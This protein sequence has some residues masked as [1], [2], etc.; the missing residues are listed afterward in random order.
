MH[1]DLCPKCGHS[2]YIHG[3]WF[4][5]SYHTMYKFDGSDADSTEPLSMKCREDNCYC[6]LLYGDKIL[7]E[8]GIW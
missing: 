7:T 1:Y 8:I 5:S 6:R 4:N 2:I 3:L